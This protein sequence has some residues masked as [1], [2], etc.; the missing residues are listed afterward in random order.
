MEKKLVTFANLGEII[1]DAKAM[2]GVR[3][4]QHVCNCLFPF[5]GEE[6]A[7]LFYCKDSE[8]WHVVFDFVELV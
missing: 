8:F 5:T 2:K 7:P 4:G 6:T 3:I 1:K